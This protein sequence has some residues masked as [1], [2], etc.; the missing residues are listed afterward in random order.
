MA[1]PRGIAHRQIQV[2]GPNRK[3]DPGEECLFT[4]IRV[5][6]DLVPNFVEKGHP[7]L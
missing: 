4:G 5:R 2:S 3:K 7:V 6:P 1:K